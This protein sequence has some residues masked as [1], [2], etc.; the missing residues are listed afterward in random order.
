[1]RKMR[2]VSM[3]AGVA[4][5][6]LLAGCGGSA[7]TPMTAK[8]AHAMQLMDPGIAECPASSPADGQAVA[9]ATNAMR[10]SRGL[11][12]VSANATLGRVA[13]AHACDMARRGRMTHIG[14]TTTGPA[15]RVKAAGYL[16]AV[17]AEN[18]AAG[19]FSRG[20]VLEEW[21]A[22]QGHRANILIPQMRDVGIG[23]AIG[24]DGKTVFWAAVYSVQR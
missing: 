24:P 7:S 23:H 18:I 5:L 15:Q 14:T 20:R 2:W 11:P 22:S 6:G 3:A 1:M 13:A 8:D 16:P 10:A 9:A 12:P 19:P 21:N 17:T 4:G